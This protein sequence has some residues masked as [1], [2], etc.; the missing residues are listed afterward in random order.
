MK[1]RCRDRRIG[2]PRRP[3][4]MGI[5]NINDDSFSGDGTL[6]T[7]I[8]LSLAKQMIE[9]GADIIDVGAESARTNRE[10]IADAEEVERLRPFLNRFEQMVA[11]GVRWDETQLWP[12]LL[13]VNTWRPPVVKEILKTGLVDI[14]NDIGGLPDVSN[15]R[16]CAD[17]GS[18]LILMHTVG[19]PKVSQTDR[20][21]EDVVG[22]LIGFF[23][24]KM[25][26]AADAG[27]PREQIVLDP[28]IDFAKQRDDNL[29]VYRELEGLQRFGRPVL[30]PVSRKT[31][32]GDV[33]RIKDPAERD[34]GT[35]ACAVSGAMRGAQILRVHNVEAVAK[36]LKVVD[37]FRS[38]SSSTE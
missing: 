28:G 38:G 1:L 6:D 16:L 17:A 35:I 14:L 22:E 23:S 26:E 7:D 21:W 4:I 32:I 30:L 3:L 5:V 29:T 19:P 36:S 8:V 10:A 2:F 34:A 24:L 20:E 9:E 31:V 37:L 15:A 13:S 25:E 12:P 33:L 27:L 18:A 11:N